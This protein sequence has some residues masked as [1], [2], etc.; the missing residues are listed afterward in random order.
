MKTFIDIHSNYTYKLRQ[1]IK[2]SVGCWI[3]TLTNTLNTTTKVSFDK[4]NYRK[5]LKTMYILFFSK[6][7][8]HIS[9]SINALLTWIWFYH[10]IVLKMYATFSVSL[11][12]TCKLNLSRLLFKTLFPI[13][14]YF[15]HQ[16]LKLYSFNFNL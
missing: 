4:E 8:S 1:L 2:R 6:I 15:F 11:G 13:R 7:I 10:L 16:I 12:V 9:T 3:K 5:I 14:R